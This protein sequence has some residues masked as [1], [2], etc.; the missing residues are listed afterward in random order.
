MGTII[1][2]HSS[3]SMVGY[4]VGAI[5]DIPINEKKDKEE[6]SDRMSFTITKLNIH[7]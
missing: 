4:S 5:S 2:A 6:D 3:V 1:S 7:L